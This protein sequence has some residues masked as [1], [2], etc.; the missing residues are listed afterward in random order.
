MPPKVAKKLTASQSQR[1]ISNTQAEPRH[2]SQEQAAQPDAEI[3]IDGDNQPDAD[4]PLSSADSNVADVT[5]AST[6]D[7]AA[8][9]AAD[10]AA[11]SADEVE[12]KVSSKKRPA[13]KKVPATDG[14]KRK[15]KRKHDPTNFQAYIHKS[16]SIY[17]ILTPFVYIND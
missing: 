6:A 14:N 16:L 9:S 8:A 10:T 13:G 15:R 5:M 1:T 3:Q 17:P 4:D 12:T 7:G 11:S 2:T